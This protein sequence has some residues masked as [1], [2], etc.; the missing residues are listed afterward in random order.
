MTQAISRPKDVVIKAP[1]I[2]LRTL[3]AMLNHF[4]LKGERLD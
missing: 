2:K 3:F 1:T 4:S